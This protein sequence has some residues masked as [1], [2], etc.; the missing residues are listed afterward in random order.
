[1]QFSSVQFSSVVGETTPH[2]R[3]VHAY[4]HACMG[5][6]AHTVGKV[7]KSNFCPGKNKIAMNIE[8]RRLNK[9][10]EKIKDLT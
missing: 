6:G 3:H 5:R 9:C 2:N 8:M 10:G 4:M 7:T 1:M